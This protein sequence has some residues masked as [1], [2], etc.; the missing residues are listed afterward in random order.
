[1]ACYSTAAG[2]SLT[3]LDL[4]GHAHMVDV[5]GK[6]P[7]SREATASGHIVLSPEA[8]QLITHPPVASQSKGD[9]LGVARIA[10]IMAAKNT[11]TLIPLCHTVSLTHVAVSFELCEERSLVAVS[12]CVR[13]EG[14]TGVEMESLTAVTVALLTLY[15]MTKSASKGHIISN[16]KLNKKKGGKSGEYTTTSSVV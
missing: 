8:F 12:A 10:G 13:C 11:P 2:P 3:H 5:G 7:S 14:V 4:Q 16:I 6:T 1:M 9:V 15:D